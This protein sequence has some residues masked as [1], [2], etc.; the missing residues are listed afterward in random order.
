MRVFSVCYRRWSFLHLK[1]VR[2][3]SI[4]QIHI[5]CKALLVLMFQK[6]GKTI[7]FIETKSRIHRLSCHFRSNLWV[8]EHFRKVHRFLLNVK[9]VIKDIFFMRYLKVFVIKNGDDF[10]NSRCAL[11]LE[12][13]T[14]RFLQASFSLI[15]C[16]FLIIYQDQKYW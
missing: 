13:V 10:I 14:R 2:C 8:M 15:S 12:C 5:V 11:L 9:T 16:Y 4:F 3:I 6:K 1:A 7:F